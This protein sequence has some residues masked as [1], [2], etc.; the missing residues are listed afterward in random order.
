M[1]RL[2]RPANLA[3]GKGRGF[4]GALLNRSR[5]RRQPI[6]NGTLEATPSVAPPVQPN[7]KSLG[8]PLPPRLPFGN[9]FLVPRLLGTIDTA[10]P[11]DRL[12]RQ[13]GLWRAPRYHDFKQPW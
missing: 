13:V 5:L 3:T 11:N 6:A 12:G 8:L 2:A 10:E 1:V 4:G 7:R 9:Q